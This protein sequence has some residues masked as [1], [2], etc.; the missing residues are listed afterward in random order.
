MDFGEVDSHL[1]RACEEVT[2]MY[3]VHVTNL[4]IPTCVDTLHDVF[5]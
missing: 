3:V 5:P 1:H 2:L 4:N